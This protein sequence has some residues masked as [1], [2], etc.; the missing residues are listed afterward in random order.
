M[1][2][3]SIHAA[4]PIRSA[5]KS[6]KNIKQNSSILEEFTNVPSKMI[7][8]LS[9]NDRM[10]IKKCYRMNKYEARGSKA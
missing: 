7:K 8:S 4:A 3:S 1:E 9:D 6:I 10:T 2:Y 5:P